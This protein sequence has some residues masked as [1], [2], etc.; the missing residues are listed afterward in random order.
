MN[1]DKHRFY[2]FFDKILSISKF[3]ISIIKTLS[4]RNESNIY[5]L[6]DIFYVVA[7]CYRDFFFRKKDFIILREFNTIPFLISA[8]FLIPVSKYIILNVNH[9]FQK[10]SKS[11]IHSFAIHCFDFFGFTYLCFEGEFNLLKFKREIISIPFPMEPLIST[12]SKSKCDLISIG[13]IGSYR[14]EKNI[15]SLLEVLNL[16]KGCE[17]ILGTDK[18]SLLEEYKGKGWTVYNTTDYQNYLKAINGIDIL[19]VNYSKDSYNFRH[20]GVITD[21]IYQGKLV[22]VPK[23]EF[24][25]AQILTPCRVGELFES[26]D[27]IPFIIENKLD[28]LILYR[29]GNIK[30]YIE[31]RSYN[32]VTQSFDYQLSNRG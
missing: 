7:N 17:L 32:L 6:F 14:E 20:S 31:Y 26:L 16:I 23:F 22:I 5:L 10:A 11:R 25:S 3:N 21:F 2:D 19:I 1:K 28:E 29:E 27:E 12:H 15:E 9:N 30:K 24:F 18:V 8:I 13:F 4:A